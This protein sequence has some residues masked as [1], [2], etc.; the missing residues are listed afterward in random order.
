MRGQVL[1]KGEKQR[2]QGILYHDIYQIQKNE[3]PAK[4]ISAESIFVFFSTSKKA[5]TISLKFFK[6]MAFKN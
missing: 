1:K 5:K 2:V 6:I 3:F 4:F